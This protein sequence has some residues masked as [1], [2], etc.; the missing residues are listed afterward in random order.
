MPGHTSYVSDAGEL[1]EH[2]LA[3]VDQA[4]ASD[5]TA[6]AGLSWPRP[7][8]EALAIAARSSA[9]AQYWPF[10]AMN[11]LAFSLGHAWWTDEKRLLVPCFISVGTDDFTV[12]TGH[13]GSFASRDT[14]LTTAN[15]AEAAD[16]AAGLAEQWRNSRG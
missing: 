16:V 4:R 13:Y 6:R 11:I 9:L 10:W 15:P 7:E 2:W 14:V 1:A 12:S 3:L 5:D 8:S